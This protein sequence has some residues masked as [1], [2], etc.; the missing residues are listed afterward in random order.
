MRG[1]RAPE[2]RRLTLAL[3]SLLPATAARAERR[4]PFG[5]DAQL[6]EANVREQVQRRLGP[7]LEEMAPG[8]AELKYIDVR[9]AKAISA[10]ATPGFEEQTPGAE[11]VADH[12]EVALT[13]DSKLPAAV[14]QGSEGPP[15]EQA[16]D[17][18][19]SRR[20]PRA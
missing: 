13:L 8:Q 15:Q 4:P 20:S 10:E 9:V 11:F 17:A 1:S 14:P 7:V 12:I 16:G 19:R 2:R 18:R 3:A 5:S 6:L